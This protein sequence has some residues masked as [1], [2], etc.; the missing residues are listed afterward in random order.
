MA[1]TI[2]YLRVSTDQQDLNNQ[3]H[4][5]ELY[6]KKRHLQIDDWVEVEI[7]SRKNMHDRRI[8]ELIQGLKK[9]DKLI[10][11]ELSRLAR[12][13]RVTPTSKQTTESALK[14]RMLLLRR[15]AV[16][17]PVL[18]KMAIHSVKSS[19]NSTALV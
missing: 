12:S 18:S 3:K 7:S 16:Q 4:E 6:A 19:K 10:V 1:K 5:I 13:M 11:S 15:C 9:G 14:K 8:A 2:A 17:L